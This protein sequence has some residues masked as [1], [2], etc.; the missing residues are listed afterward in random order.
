MPA[1]QFNISVFS[2][3]QGE[4][5]AKIYVAAV[6]DDHAEAEALASY[7]I[8]GSILGP[9][10]R[11]ST[12][13]Q[14]KIPL[15][16]RGLTRVGDRTA[17]LAEAMLPDPC[18]W[19]PGLPFLYRAVG[20]ISGSSAPIA[21]EQTFGTRSLAVVKKRL[22]L[23]GKPWFP[24]IVHRDEVADEASLEQWRDSACVLFVDDADDELC[25]A[26]SETGVWLMTTIGDDER[27]PI[28][29]LVRLGRHPCVAIVVVRSELAD[30]RE[31]R[32]A[33][34]NTLLARFSDRKFGLDAAEATD[35][36]VPLLLDDGNSLGLRWAA[37]A[38]LPMIVMR[39]I[40]R[41]V[42]L[43]EARAACDVLQSDLADKY[44]A[45]GYWV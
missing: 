22:V 15:T 23:N 5:A 8:S 20:E 42:S 32:T 7:R 36:L 41:R 2:D 39:P 3:A 13:L 18:Y 45:A 4:A 29:E 33:A 12:T 19:T 34:P 27:S 24:R 40:D 26:A 17:L 1:S 31:L 35:V 10:C 37:T 11:Y 6:P 16:H 28:E 44:D 9:A 21:F 30:A 38:E 43:E 25:R 14:A